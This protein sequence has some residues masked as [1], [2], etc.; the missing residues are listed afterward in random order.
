MKAIL[1]FFSA[2]ILVSG[3][4]SCKKSWLDGKPKTELVIPTTISDYQAILDNTIQSAGYNTESPSL[5]EAGAGDF[6]IPTNRWPNVT[7]EK[8]RNAYTWSYS[9]DFYGGITNLA[10]WL[11]PY[12]RIFKANVVLE[13]IEKISPKTNLEKVAWQQVKGS[14]LFF[15]AINHYNVAQIFCGDYQNTT[16]N[17]DPGI[18]LRLS[19][20]IYVPSVRASIGQTYTQI[21]EDIKA[22]ESLLPVSAPVPNGLLYK[23]RPT[24][25][26]ANALLARVYLSMS[27]YENALQYA[28]KSL[29]LY[30]TLKDYNSYQYSFPPA[31]TAVP[32]FE[33]SS[34]GYNPEVIL[35]MRLIST[36]LLSTANLVVDS[37]LFKLYN[38]N[39]RRRDVFFK[40]SPALT[41]GY[42]IR[43]TY[44][45]STSLFDGL[46]TDEIY[47]IRAECN[48]RKSDTA[49]AMADLNKL[50]RKR[51]RTTGPTPQ[52]YQ[53]ISATSSA[54]AL[55]KVLLERRKELVFRGVRWSDLR[56]LNRDPQ[57]AIILTRVTDGHTN[58]LPPNDLRYVL[59]IPDNVVL[60]TGM[61]QNPRK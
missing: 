55:I 49:S 6:Y 22:A 19:S 34:T 26:A 25:T 60:L 45:G 54:D 53:R 18:P 52:P 23:L 38:V 20:D 48:A 1:Y 47:L 42:T 29:S 17:Q 30:D 28:T 41:G 37:N 15:R 33:T 3:L 4:L 27:D 9:D 31:A 36:P 5:G 44:D 58:I 59:P 7:Q 24:K 21:I 39:D 46:A 51:W 57:L 10:D 43:G 2:W 16:A 32:L 35:N 56:R 13:G 8:D 14:A 61:P 11:L 12:E 50:Y 40:T